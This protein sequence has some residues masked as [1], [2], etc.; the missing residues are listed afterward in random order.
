MFLEQDEEGMDCTQLGE[1]EELA[2]QQYPTPGRDNSDMLVVHKNGTDYA[3]EK[4]QGG[5][6]LQISGKFVQRRENLIASAH[7]RFS[8]AFI[9]VMSENPTG[10][11]ELL[12]MYEDF[13]RFQGGAEIALP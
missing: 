10:I 11:K 2:G 9:G 6:L 13:M 7:D 12:G 1:H 8:A 5:M 4:S 3:M